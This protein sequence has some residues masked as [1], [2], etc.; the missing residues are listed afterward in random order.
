MPLLGGG[1][2][3]A[4][5]TRVP[6]SSSKNLDEEEKKKKRRARNSNEEIRTRGDRVSR[7]RTLPG[8]N[9]TGPW[10]AIETFLSYSKAR[11][12]Y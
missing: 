10:K 5:F 9:T 3:N 12:Q 7:Y 4:T 2:P 11:I 8:R 6:P 1:T